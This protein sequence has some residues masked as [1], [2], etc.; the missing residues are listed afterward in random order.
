MIGNVNKEFLAYADKRVRL[1]PFRLKEDFETVKTVA[2]IDRLIDRANDI[3]NGASVLGRFGWVNGHSYENNMKRAEAYLSALERGEYPLAGKFAEPGFTVVDHSFIEKDG[4]LH[5]FYNRGYIGYEWDT[6]FAD[7]F[8]HATT[9]DLIHWTIEPPAL[10]S[11]KDGFDNHQVWAPGV[12]KKGDTYYMYYT[13]VNLH[14]SQ[15]I[16]M[17][18]SKDL[19]HW[20]RYENNPV[21]TPGNWGNWSADQWSDCR[22]PMVLI[23]D[24]K[25]RTAY[26]YYCTMLKGLERAEATA[27]GMASSKD[28]VHWK[29]EGAHHFDHCEMTLESPFVLKHHG[30]YYLFYT[31][32]AHGTYYAYSENPVSGWSE[33]HELMGIQDPDCPNTFPSCSEVFRFQDKWYI[34]V[35]ERLSTCEQYLELYELF[36]NEDNT[37]SLGKRVEPSFKK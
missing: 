30:L 4:V 34:S 9:T 15:A 33:G 28:M 12:C 20:E 2:V 24:D 31:N 7:I 14:I 25:D 8:G 18:T 19:Y 17:A 3:A 27:L 21:L 11:F 35:A 23:D 29:D 6:R 13:G 16:C 26:L 22:D 37:V 36:W 1:A 5:V 32:C 10:T